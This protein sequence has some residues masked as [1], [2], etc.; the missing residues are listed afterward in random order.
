M[1][2]GALE[3]VRVVEFTDEV[4]SYCGR[5]LADL[6]A[7][8]IKIEPPGGGFERRTP[9]WFH[10]IE[11]PDT[12][13]AFWVN[14][15]SK[16]SVVLDLDTEEGRAKARKLALSADIVLED[17][18]VGY[19]AGR[20]LG[21]DELHREK[22][23]LVYTSIT[24]FGQTGPHAKYA[25]TDIVGQAMSGIMTLAGDPDDPPN[26]IVGHQANIGAC[27]HASQGT[28]MALIH[29]ENT[30]QGQ[31][32][33]V[34]AQEAS[35]MSQETAMQTWDLQ[36]RNRT[37]TG[38]RGM[39]PIPL[40]AFGVH[41][42]KDGYVLLY[43]MAPGGAD[44]PVL[45][46]WMAERGMAEDL[47]EEPYASLITQLN[48]RFITQ[49]M[50]D[51]G[52]AGAAVAQLAHVSD[53]IHR[54]I[55]SMSAVEAYEE[56]QK[57]ALLFGVVSTPESLAHNTQLRARDWYPT[58]DID[59]LNEKTEF[60]GAPY[61]LSETPVHIGRPPRLGEHTAEVLAALG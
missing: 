33:D 32:V 53:V 42:A 54:F 28:M 13:L 52:S 45:I 49:V 46:D 12:S 30:G 51:P 19:L 26:I 38:E 15:T 27:I 3:G 57:R 43:V 61:R 36:K 59:F 9:P 41:Q 7:E 17:N 18:P 14:N 25:Y 34:S 47:Q 8:V 35:S 39:I 37:R 23:S 20:G 48:M 1:T 31:Q 60:P 40:P 44:M 58:L 50:T 24:G 56:G 16:K 11:G 5:L 2:P 4:G 10:G 21:Y 55:G 29:A 22:P 6:G